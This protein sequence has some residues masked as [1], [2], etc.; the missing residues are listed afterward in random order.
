M[1]YSIAMTLCALLATVSV[2]LSSCSKFKSSNEVQTVNSA[3]SPN[4]VQADVAK[5]TREAAENNAKANTIS[6]QAEAKAN[7][8]LAKEKAEAEAKAADKSVVAV[9][10]AAVIQAEG[11]TQI[12]IAK[13]EA[14]EGD[15]QQQ[16]RNKATAHFQAVM[17]RAKAAKKGPFER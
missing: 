11:A 6:K 14:L 13:C 9:A 7:E 16:C 5:A 17:D 1:R 3:K 2:G 8:E 15:A 10:D 12:A 4:E